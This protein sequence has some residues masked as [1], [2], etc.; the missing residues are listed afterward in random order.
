MSKEESKE[1]SEYAIIIPKARK[2]YLF[3]RGKSSRLNTNDFYSLLDNPFIK[4]QDFIFFCQ[5]EIPLDTLIFNI[6][7]VS[8]NQVE[9]DL[10]DN[11]LIYHD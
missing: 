8:I 10:T 6:L 2:S 11:I 4:K 1:K 5:G 3:P 7:G 9:E